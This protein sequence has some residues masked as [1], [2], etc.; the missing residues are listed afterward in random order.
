MTE[1]ILPTA[2]GCMRPWIWPNGKLHVELCSMGQLRLGDIAVWLDRTNFIAHRVVTLG[3]DELATRAD[4][5]RRDDPPIG[6]NQLLGRAV[7]FSRGPVSYRLDSALLVLLS[8]VGREP[9]ARLMTAA[10]W[11]RDR[12]RRVSAWMAFDRRDPR[13]PRRRRRG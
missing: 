8:D 12:A 3:V 7:R 13:S 6:P 11:G 10:R 1:V 2:G 9:W 5:S 4:S